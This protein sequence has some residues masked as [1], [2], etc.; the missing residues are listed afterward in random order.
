MYIL[1]EFDDYQ[2]KC[3]YDR[4]FP[5]I[6]ITKTWNNKR[7]K[8]F[9]RQFLS[10]L[11]HAFTIHKAQGL[12]VE[13]EVNLNIILTFAVSTENFLLSFFYRWL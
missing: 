4:W 11:G 13:D 12:T 3:L 10:L 5:I 8:C 1:I 6:L 2:E 9:R 7:L